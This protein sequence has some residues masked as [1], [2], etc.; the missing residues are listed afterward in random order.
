MAVFQPAAILNYCSKRLK[1]STFEILRLKLY[2]EIK[3]SRSSRGRKSEKRFCFRI[4]RSRL[5]H[6]SMK[7]RLSAMRL[8]GSSIH[9]Q[10]HRK[11]PSIS[12]ANCLLKISEKMSAEFLSLSRAMLRFLSPR[13]VAF[14]PY[15]PPI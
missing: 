6:T 12:C 1:L 5:L 14:V 2:Y 7:T 10:V 15:Y 9:T 4:F 3:K 8:V 11:L 13:L